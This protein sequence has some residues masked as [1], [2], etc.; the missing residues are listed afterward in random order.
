MTGSRAPCFA[1]VAV[2]AAGLLAPALLAAAGLDN[3]LISR[4]AE[5]AT[6][7][8]RFA[9]PNRY[10]QHMPQVAS[11]EVVVSLLR[12]DA[13]GRDPGAARARDSRR[14]AGRALAALSEVEYRSSGGDAQLILRFDRAVMA[15]VRQQGDLRALELVVKADG[16]PTREND[17]RQAAAPV[18]RPV[19]EAM[20]A[21]RRE[22]A[23]AAARR[24][25]EAAP[26][27][28][29]P[30][31]GEF[32]INLES[33]REPLTAPSL[34]TL[35]VAA[36]MRV[37]LAKAN[38]DGAEWNRLRLGFFA[39][40]KEA[41][42][43]MARHRERYPRAW[44]VRVGP[45]ER[46]RA[47]AASPRPDAAEPKT[48]TPAAARAALPPATSP[49]V[50][51]VP[52]PAAPAEPSS[53]V[54]VVASPAVPVAA[55]ADAAVPV[56]GVRRLSDAELA[57]LMEQ[58]RMAVIAGDYTLA[59]Q[60]YTKVLGEPD[61]P[62]ARPAQEFLA[63]TRER[64]GQTAHAVAEYRRYLERYPDGEDSERV[65]QRL[66][67]LLTA[68]ESPRAPLGRSVARAAP[69]PW[70]LYGGFSQYYRRDAGEFGGQSVTLQSA[71][72]SDGDFV[73]RRSG[74]RIEL[75]ARATGSHFLDLMSEDE[76]AGDQSRVYQLYVDV[77]D[78]DWGL[79]A[80]LG[81][82]SLRSYGVLGR[83]DG[84]H[85]TYDW[86]EDRRVNVLSGLPVF[87][88]QEGPDSERIFY[89]L[90]L[91]FNGL[92]RGLDASVFFNTQQL[93]DLDDREAVGG[94]VRYFDDARSLIT[95]LD[96]DLGYGELNS[97]A[98]MGNWRFANLLTL[99][100]SLNLRRSPFLTTENAII[101]QPVGTLDELLLLFDEDQIRQL[102]LDR[103]GEMRTAT[104]GIARPLFERFQVN[105][106]VTVSDFD[107][108]TAS[109]GVPAFEGLG[110]EYYYSL[111]LTG[112]SLFREGDTSILGLRYLDGSTASTLAVS[113]D[114]RFPV[115]SRL[116]LNPRLRLYRREM[117]SD[118]TEQW[119]A[120]PSMRV[121]YVLGRN[122][123]LELDLGGEWST[124]DSAALNSDYSIYYVYLGYRADF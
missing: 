116:R 83:F 62:F 65:R 67:A 122:Y 37:Y 79:G 77:A 66:T 84:A 104:L 78:R 8:V 44:V 7:Q 61:N 10:V 86:R 33:A 6:I 123:R 2:S 64:N 27:G 52:S 57:E 36:G 63:L 105:A 30:S 96:Y 70:A 24:R 46:Q 16:E 38:I 26:A 98:A 55:A 22:R 49:T 81:R 82:Q 93:G 20:P 76:G 17:P 120:A 18:H 74:R 75:E 113:L 19:R 68:P 107:G 32:A 114:Q 88:P 94:E 48:A 58:A 110:T 23:E 54:P 119:S 13:C 29:G 12:L 11:R 97:L 85:L 31:R 99:N 56:A 108:T 15:G 72:L 90:G 28:A 53:P 69:S 34:A 42:A 9:C 21:Q 73:A 14:P 47:Q 112:M 50:P 1:R 41:A 115:G 59:V 35:G 121:F 102:A 109:G 51:V 117:L 89:A 5:S 71:L 87:D 60:L 101:G 111:Y 124:R 45:V 40:E 3:V 100:A 4:N 92:F 95:S 103:S 118:G 91:D 106:D 25:L 39:S 43:E 80:R